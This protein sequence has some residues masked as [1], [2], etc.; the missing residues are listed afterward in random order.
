MEPPTIAL[1]SDF[2]QDDFFVPSVKAVI[3]SLNPA[4]RL[5]DITHTVPSYD[6]RAAGFI[7][8][9]CFRF[10]P[11]GAIFLSVVDPGVGGERRILLAR[12]EK[13]DFIAP[14]N[15]LLTLPLDGARSLELRSIANPKYGLTESSRTFEGRDRMAPAA[16]WL[17][18]GTPPSEFGPLLR[19]FEKHPVRKPRLEKGRLSGEVAYVDKFG[20]LITNIPMSLLGKLKAPPPRSLRLKVK[21][22]TVTAFLGAYSQG[23]PGEP[24]ALAG[25][26]GTVEVAVR[27][28]SAAARLGASAGDE[29]HIAAG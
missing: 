20:N 17:S 4:V 14:D 9:A 27:E 1:L 16:A 15:G 6:V 29:V 10:F 21:G 5:V 8:S 19:G 7:L 3:L 18:L 22:R 28:D 13:Y 11:A 2:G 23:R 12:T 26:L 25:S 24:F